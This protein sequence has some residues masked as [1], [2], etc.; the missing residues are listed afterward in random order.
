M[1]FHTITEM[2]A[3]M[4]AREVAPGD[5]IECGHC[6]WSGTTTKWPSHL[7]TCPDPT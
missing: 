3:S 2:F 5:M 4:Q 7:L 6:D 1:K